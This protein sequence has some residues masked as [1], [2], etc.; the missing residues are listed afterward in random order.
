MNTEELIAR[1]A[2]K[3]KYA[4]E[5]LYRTMRG[6]L[7]LQAKALLAGDIAAAED[8]VDEAFVDLWSKPGS[9]SGAGNA[10][11]WL[12]RI[13]RNKAIDQVRRSNKT[14]GQSPLDCAFQTP[15]HDRS[16]E[17]FAIDQ[18]SASFLGRA[19][20]NLPGSQQEVLHLFYFVELSVQEIA[21]QIEVPVGTV[22]SRLFH[23]R[24]GLLSSVAPAYG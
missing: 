8:A 10:D 4:F 15:S 14:K 21:E 1:V 13:V 9:F 2:N 17:E 22:K 11:G 23:G 18:N 3:D 7:V 12:R 6:K 16:P 19:L 5:Q 20:K 24:Q